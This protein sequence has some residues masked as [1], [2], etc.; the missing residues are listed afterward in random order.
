MV[1]WPMLATFI[2]A[3]GRVIMAVRCVVIATIRLAI[4]TEAIIM[5]AVITTEDTIEDIIAII[6]IIMDIII[7][8]ITMVDIITANIAEQKRLSS[9]SLFL[10]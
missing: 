10:F 2:A 5:V 3:I 1:K 4:T 7:T 6:T 9:E 8:T